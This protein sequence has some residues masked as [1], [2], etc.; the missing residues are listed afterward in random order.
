[1]D[2][3]K[4]QQKIECKLLFISNIQDKAKIR[5][6]LEDEL[7]A[8]PIIEYKWKLRKVLEEEKKRKQ[9]FWDRIKNFFKRKTQREKE[10]TSKLSKLQPRGFRTD[11]I[12][13][14]LSDIE[15]K[16][17]LNINENPFLEDQYCFPQSYLQ[18]WKV[19]N[20]LKQYFCI[21][22]SFTLPNEIQDYFSQRPFIMFDLQ[23]PLQQTNYHSLVLTKQNWQD[24]T[25]I[26]I[27]DLHLAERNDKIFEIV[28]KWESTSVLERTGKY[29]G[30]VANKIKSFF[31]GDSNRDDGKQ[32]EA[33]AL[34]MSFDQRF[35]NP[36][37]QLRKFIKTV[38]KKVLANEVDFVVLTG[39]IV[40]YVIKSKYAGMK[41][42]SDRLRFKHTNWKTFQDIILNK[43][44]GQKYEG[45]LE[46]GQ[47]LLCPLFTIVGNHDFRT[48]HYDLTW[49]NLYKKLGLT[50]SE[51]S[52]LNE[53]YS[54][55]PITSLNKSHLGLKFY[56]KKINP[57][58]DFSLT[59][60]DIDLIF[61]NSGA[62]S[63]KNFK[64]LLSG[65]PSVTGLTD[66][67]IQ[68]LENISKT[69]NLSTKEVLLLIHGPP[70]NIGKYKYFRQRLQSIGKSKVRKKIGQFK[71]SI[72]KKLGRE[73]DARRIDRAFN[74]KRGTV[75]SNWEELIQF[76]KNYTT[77]TLSGHT[78]ILK[79]F[80]L[81]DPKEKSTVYDA[82]PFILQKLKNPA[83]VYYDIYSE[84][85]NSS[86][87][88][89]KNGPFIVQT[90][91]LGLGNYKKPEIVGAYREIEIKNGKLNSFKVKFL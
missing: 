83:A 57:S 71:E 69:P 49:A 6:F 44:S 85:H 46:E 13:L 21:D 88:I 80:R 40:D 51:A 20:D 15:E 58:L 52:A 48:H 27:T 31:T 12:P 33:K 11:P 24:F 75:S 39:D 78:H 50:S 84:R 47:E 5:K 36:N 32:Q 61:L 91:A 25:F 62:D 76:C 65:H 54:A 81:G 53:L 74:V 89:K 60:G 70:I 18:K 82:P 86:S 35:I 90:P 2:Q 28:S 56:L 4:E 8:V 17:L 66:D 37:N 72:L 30:K 64:D 59:L 43:Q 16:R 19:F 22:A 3:E 55:S 14:K 34:K 77:L 41:I 38:N 87:K 45:R 26:Q 42:D 68:Y 79:E 63:F 1:M 10:I 73:E 9:T 7:S 29:I 23:G 67:Q